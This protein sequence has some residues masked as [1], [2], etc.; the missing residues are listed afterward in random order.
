MACARV[1]EFL[2]Q[3]HL[4]FTERSIGSDPEALEELA[5]FDYSRLPVTVID[6]QAVSGFDRTRLGAL[7]QR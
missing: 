2:S 6:G 3:R 4:Q 5:R 1:K 7:L